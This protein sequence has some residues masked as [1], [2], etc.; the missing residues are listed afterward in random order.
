METP[1]SAHCVARDRN[2]FAFSGHIGEPETLI[3]RPNQSIRLRYFRK[4][5]CLHVQ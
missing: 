5:S 4:A 1:I 3:F 2:L